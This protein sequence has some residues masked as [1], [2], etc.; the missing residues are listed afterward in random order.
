MYGTKTQKVAW[1]I[2]KRFHFTWISPKAWV[3]NM[4]I[5]EHACDAL[6]VLLGPNKRFDPG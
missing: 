2:D 6:W 4:D 5:Q 1:L 3:A